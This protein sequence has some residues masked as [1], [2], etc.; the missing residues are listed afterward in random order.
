MGYLSKCIECGELHLHV[1]NVFSKIN[2]E[3][4]KRLK[5]AFLK[6][7]ED[8]GRN[9]C[10]LP[11]GN[12]ILVRTSTDDLFIGLEYDELTQVIEIL[13]LGD[14]MYQASDKLIQKN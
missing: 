10:E 7:E 1:G 12:K 4:L 6:F 8:F 13:E 9:F 3:Q 14:L 11:N 2:Y 5:K